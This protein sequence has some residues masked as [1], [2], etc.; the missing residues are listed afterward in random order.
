MSLAI[1]SHLK[2][3]HVCGSSVQPAMYRFSRHATNNL[4]V[5][6]SASVVLVSGAETCL[7]AKLDPN[8]TLF[9]IQFFLM[10]FYNFSS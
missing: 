8:T 4:L 6:N 5:E 3:Q 1:W 2:N 10:A 7:P 9:D